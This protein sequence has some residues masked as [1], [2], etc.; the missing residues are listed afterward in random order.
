M[1]P[2]SSA[3]V[4]M[5]ESVSALTAEDIEDDYDVEFRYG[6]APIGA[7]QGAL[8]RASRLLRVCKQDAVAGITN[9]LDRIAAQVDRRGEPAKLFDDMGTTVLEQL[10]LGAL[11]RGFTRNLR[12]M[13]AI[14]RRRRDAT[15]QALA[16]SLPAAVS[17]G[18]AA[19]L[20]VIR[21]ATAMVRRADPRRGRPRPR[22][23]H[24]RSQLALVRTTVR[25]PALVLGFGALDEPAIR[26]GLATLARSTKHNNRRRAHRPAALRRLQLWRVA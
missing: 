3:S 17:S 21:A 19:G 2:A 26:R 20:H 6:R 4:H 1:T 7:L 10:T 12:R 5:F 22:V 16:T 15:L 13:R 8:P 24:R 18:V 14:Y 9:R 23:A 25:P 11:L